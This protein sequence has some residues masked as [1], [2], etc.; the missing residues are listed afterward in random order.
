MALKAEYLSILARMYALYD[1]FFA[2]TESDQSTYTI[3]CNV[4]P[5][6]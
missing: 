5:V 2:D 3:Y 1:A 4:Y 6:V